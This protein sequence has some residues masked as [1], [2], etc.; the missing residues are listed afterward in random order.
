MGEKVF[1]PQLGE[2]VVEG[3]IE[4]WLVQEGDKVNAYD[5]ICEVTTDKVTTEVPSTVSGTISE[6]VAAEGETVAVGALICSIET[7]EP[8]PEQHNDPETKDAAAVLYSPA[9]L[10]LAHEHNLDPSAIQGTGEGGRVTRKDML[11]ASAR[12]KQFNEDQDRVIPVTSVRATIA[13]RMVQSKNEAPHAWTMVECDVT[14][15]V[16][17]RNRVKDEFMKKEGIKLTYLPFFIKAVTEALKEYP[18]INSQWGGDKI[19][20]KKAVNISIAVATDTALF[21]PVIKHADQKNIAEIAKTADELIRKC[22][23]GKLA[24]DDT[25]DGTFTVNNT[26]AFGSIA[27]API[28]NPP[29]AAILSVE[30]IVKRPVVIANNMIAIRDM[31]NICLSLDHR[32]LDGLLCGRFL[33]NVRKRLENYDP[34]TKLY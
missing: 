21:V 24:A 1:M 29:Q 3:T 14:N 12:K 10:R 28:V 15:M 18:I 30:A 2:S 6:I 19:I 17:Y 16:E 32:V 5:P 7:D 33:H 22:K 20:V 8:G 34:E 13:N 26:G 23:E 11:E 25:S 31:V 4:R 27:S 9:V